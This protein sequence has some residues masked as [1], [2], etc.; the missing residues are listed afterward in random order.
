MS[1]Y[2]VVAL[3]AMGG[4]NAPSEI[5]KGAV[6]AVNENPDVKV[7]L[8]GDEGKI[9]TVLGGYSYNHDQVE[10]IHTSQEKV[11]RLYLPAV[12]APYWLAARS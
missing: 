6:D 2:T 9:R 1:N 8:Y 4:D 7:R 10:V 12:P 3:D 5:V 11:M